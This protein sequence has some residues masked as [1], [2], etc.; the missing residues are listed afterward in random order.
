M[1]IE[2]GRIRNGLSVGIVYQ[3]KIHND[4]DNKDYSQIT[5]CFIACYVCISWVEMNKKTK[6][7][8]L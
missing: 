7:K 6:K 1:K 8:R 2:R 4:F 5:I 3:R